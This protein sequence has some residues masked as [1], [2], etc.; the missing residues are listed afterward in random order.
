VPH[1][2]EPLVRMYSRTTCGLCDEAR[3]KILALRDELAFG[4]EE[5]FVDGND[6]LERR[7][8][9][10]VPVIE[11]DGQERFEV[12]VEETSL[13]EVLAESRTLRD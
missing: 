11:V 7:Y 12:Q 10:R 4:Y 5:V 6:D 1:P 2:A 8:G 3:E 9:L 13:R